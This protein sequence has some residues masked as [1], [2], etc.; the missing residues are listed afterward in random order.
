MVAHSFFLTK[1]LITKSNELVPSYTESE[2]EEHTVPQDSFHLNVEGLG[3]PSEPFGS[4]DRFAYEGI[5]AV[6]LLHEKLHRFDP[7]FS[8]TSW[9]SSEDTFLIQPP[10]RS[11]IGGWGDFRPSDVDS[12]RS[13]T[14][15]TVK[16][17]I[18]SQTLEYVRDAFGVERN[19]EDLVPASIASP[20][21][22]WVGLLERR[23]VIENRTHPFYHPSL[24]SNIESHYESFASSELSLVNRL[25]RELGLRTGSLRVARSLPDPRHDS[26]NSGG[27]NFSGNILRRNSDKNME[28][29]SGVVPEDIFHSSLTLRF[30]GICGLKL[31]NKHSNLYVKVSLDDSGD[32]KDA[33][34]SYGLKEKLIS[35]SHIKVPQLRKKSKLENSLT[36]EGDGSDALDELN[37][38]S[39]GKPK[40]KG[41]RH[42]VMNMIKH[43]F[44]HKDKSSP[45]EEDVSS[46]TAV[47][48]V[49][50]GVL[51][52]HDTMR[53]S[54]P[55]IDSEEGPQ[56]GYASQTTPTRTQSDGYDSADRA[57]GS[58]VYGEGGSEA[59]ST[60]GGQ[61][62][63]SEV[64]DNR[65]N[66]VFVGDRIEKES[67]GMRTDSNG[68]GRHAR[69]GKTRKVSLASKKRHGFGFH[70]VVHLHPV[71]ADDVLTIKV[72]IGS[73]S[74]TL[75]GTRTVAQF[76]VPV[77]AAISWTSFPAPP[78]V[79]FDLSTCVLASGTGHTCEHVLSEAPPLL[80]PTLALSS[81]HRPHT[82]THTH[83]HTHSH[84]HILSDTNIDP[85]SMQFM[86]SDDTSST[87]RTCS[88]TS[89]V[90]ASRASSF[91]MHPVNLIPPPAMDVAQ[92]SLQASSHY[93]KFDDEISDTCQNR[94]LRAEHIDEDSTASHPPTLAMQFCL[95]VGMVGNTNQP[96]FPFVLV[97]HAEAHSAFDLLLSHL[98]D[99][100][101]RR[102]G[103]QDN[104]PDEGVLILGQTTRWLVSNFA[105]WFGIGQL[106]VH[107]RLVDVLLQWLEH[108][109]PSSASFLPLLR[110]VHEIVQKIDF[111][112]QTFVCPETNV[113]VHMTIQEAGLA[114][115]IANRLRMLSC[116]F[117]TAYPTTLNNIEEELAVEIVTLMLRLDAF[118][119]GT[120]L[121]EAR[122]NMA[123]A[124]LGG[125]RSW[126]D[127]Q[128][129]VA[130][131]RCS[132]PEGFVGALQL[133]SNDILIMSHVMKAIYRRLLRDTKHFANVF[134]GHIDLLELTAPVIH[135][136]VLCR[137]V[138]RKSPSFVS[139][140][141]FAL[142]GRLHYVSALLRRS[143]PTLDPL[144]VVSYMSP[145]VAAWSIETRRGLLASLTRALARE[146]W[147]SIST[148]N[149]HLE[150][151]E[152]VIRSCASTL[153]LITST[154][155]FAF[156]FLTVVVEMHCYVLRNFVKQLWDDCLRSVAAAVEPDRPGVFPQVA[157]N[158][159]R[160]FRG[161]QCESLWPSARAA[162]DGRHVRSGFMAKEGGF[163]RNWKI[164]YF[165]LRNSH[166]YYYFTEEDVEPRGAIHLDGARVIRVDEATFLPAHRR[167][168]D[169]GSIPDA[170]TIDDTKERHSPHV[171]QPL[172][173]EDV[174]AAVDDVAED[175]KSVSMPS[176][177]GVG[178]YSHCFRLIPR[179]FARVFY[180]AADSEEEML[181]WMREIQVASII[182][183]PVALVANSLV[184]LAASITDIWENLKQPVPGAE[185]GEHAMDA[186]PVISCDRLQVNKAI[187]GLDLSF[188]LRKEL[189]PS[190]VVKST[191]C[192]SFH[193][194]CAEQYWWSYCATRDCRR[195][196]CTLYRTVLLAASS[197]FCAVL[198]SR[199]RK[200]VLGGTLEQRT[201]KRSA[202]H[203]VALQDET[204]DSVPVCFRGSP[205]AT[206]L[207]SFLNLAMQELN[208]DD[209][210]DLQQVAQ[211]VIITLSHRLYYPALYSIL[212]TTWSMLIQRM[213]RLFY[214][215]SR[216]VGIHPIPRPNHYA[217]LVTAVY[218]ALF[219][220]FYMDG[221]AVANLSHTEY[222]SA[223]LTAVAYYSAG[224]D[225]ILGLLSNDALRYT[226]GASV[227]GLRVVLRGR[228][229]PVPALE[230]L[231]STSTYPCNAFDKIRPDATNEIDSSSEPQDPPAKMG[232]RNFA[233]GKGACYT[234][235]LA[236]HQ[237]HVPSPAPRRRE[238]QNT[239]FQGRS[240]PERPRLTRTS[241]WHASDRHALVSRAEK[242]LSRRINMSDINNND[243]DDNDDND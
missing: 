18:F 93:I 241:S 107:L 207:N 108:V 58:V 84:T 114:E 11:D 133:H 212:V 119:S 166:L 63:H 10:P 179:G 210:N 180:L 200:I 162:T 232:D 86:S 39:T 198:W 156:R 148:D 201:A 140:S 15:G 195:S 90:S 50:N 67:G 161:H 215:H 66:G 242:R 83:S 211:A 149:L 231:T 71:H 157:K 178:K 91:E 55:G 22:A 68:R 192:D 124:I 227:C 64:G 154:D 120:T 183:Q 170:D 25:L 103:F 224:T 95:D 235:A 20:Q 105:R 41:R 53:E 38:P 158:V 137:L 23:H 17:D 185:S 221:K 82:Q 122:G 28:V 220:S 202:Q 14:D 51:L 172:H 171:P 26:S 121:A 205:F 89:S 145:F 102:A 236:E 194:D 113:A 222:P 150:C 225:E 188:T 74:H 214:A 142:Y 144:P 19:R 118:V 100:E 177:K 228:N 141:V 193:E 219:D 155:L 30:I 206:K 9:I 203:G 151:A 62:S 164:R 2:R 70:D 32:D 5:V 176:R 169:V 233:E 96:P 111:Q 126:L 24:F 130:T 6:I 128:F 138:P 12:S 229:L 99:E 98:I 237:R 76:S 77:Y 123:D 54:S 21:C 104:E 175:A 189:G 36:S 239:G 8:S 72:K 187:S 87:L 197:N 92:Q 112:A 234:P 190:C 60:I 139:P 135:E 33:A 174:V 56:R 181:A 146:P 204:N 136:W 184:F 46:T 117:F 85:S 34:K 131:A 116:H 47:E 143:I 79:P 65:G 48:A 16:D 159:T 110:R 78:V 75:R 42:T 238:Q 81:R 109:R 226:S 199:I 243:D 173:E 57:C 218:K 4:V 94:L 125:L 163:P 31:P 182:P 147:E 127:C 61:E 160:S 134:G 165:V 168:S 217:A 44:S 40:K 97:P 35:S 45:C 216:T 52:G 29:P 73:S 132:P 88:E 106:F 209:L 101:C 7:P 27:T 80:P 49:D 115:E 230:L 129:Q 208:L 213:G 3:I 152:K 37:S 153:Q 167:Q 69:E 43:P 1:N 223:L 191:E 59:G 186:S 240:F 196:V 13:Y